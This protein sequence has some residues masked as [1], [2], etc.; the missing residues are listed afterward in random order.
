MGFMA[1]D[2]FNAEL[3]RRFCLVPILGVVIANRKP[4]KA[5]TAAGILMPYLGQDMLRL[6]QDKHNQLPL[7]IVHLE[8]LVRGV[9]NMVN[10]GVNHGDMRYWNVVLKPSRQGPRASR[11]ILID[12]GSELPYYERYTKAL[13]KPFLWCHRSSP[14]LQRDRQS[15]S[16]IIAAAN[17][18]NAGNSD[19][20]IAY[21]S[22]CLS[23]N[24]P[25]SQTLLADGTRSPG[26][27][28]SE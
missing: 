15:K 19:A 4:W 6:T 8:S 1:V 3:I 5:G 22:A 14:L 25:T 13:R 7:T 28:D 9:R 12:A 18:P 27:T 16:P 23:A 20:V 21:L 24:Q 11:L 17:A 2:Q 10:C 26:P